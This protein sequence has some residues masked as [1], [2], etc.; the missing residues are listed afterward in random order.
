MNRIDCAVITKRGK[1]S[2]S[3]KD[4][5]FKEASINNGKVSI[6]LK[7]NHISKERPNR[8]TIL[9]VHGYPDDHRTWSYQLDALCEE[10]NVAA[11]DLRGAGKS[12]K[13]EEQKAYNV[14]RIF[15]DLEVVI[16][17]LGNGKP[18]H[19]VAH[20]WG[21]LICWAFVADKRYSR[22]V[23]SYTAMGGPHPILAKKSIFRLLF[24]INP[25]SI[26]KALTQARKSWYIIY[27]QIPFLPELSWKLFPKFLWKTAMNLGGVPKADSLRSK[28]KEEILASSLWPMNLYRELLR[29][30]KFPVPEYIEPS[31]QVFIP[32]NDFAIRPESYK[33]HKEICSSYREF[34]FNS[35][36]WVQRILPGLITEKIKEFVW[37]TG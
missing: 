6:F 29:G 19:L 35:N 36:H 24:S 16:Q 28:T 32:V 5:T 15:E 2:E 4:N 20:D 23:K 17:F 33:L 25:V 12:S 7:Y 9:F 8:Q 13:P 37:E 22:F 11:L 3:S 30:E 10:Y 1:S 27:F 26:W 34:R 21:A 31:V 18:I 14:R